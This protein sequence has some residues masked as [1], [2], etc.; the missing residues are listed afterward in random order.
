MYVLPRHRVRGAVFR[1][2]GLS[3]GW[4]LV[5]GGGRGVAA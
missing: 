1:V 3:R 5:A 2:W 4:G